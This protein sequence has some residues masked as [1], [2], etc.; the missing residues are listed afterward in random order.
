MLKLSDLLLGDI[1]AVV[2]RI[3]YATVS[4]HPVR[5]LATIRWKDRYR[6]QSYG[7]TVQPCAGCETSFGIRSAYGQTVP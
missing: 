1:R 6:F 5:T 7:P 2:R 4:T 3:R